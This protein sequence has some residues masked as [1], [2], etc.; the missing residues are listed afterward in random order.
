MLC[1]MAQRA[2]AKSVSV[3]KNIR[4]AMCQLRRESGRRRWGGVD[5][6]LSEMNSGVMFDGT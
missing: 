6:N 3:R 1:E 5:R 4:R 2:Y